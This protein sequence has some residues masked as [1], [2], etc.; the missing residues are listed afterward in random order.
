M[1]AATSGGMLSPAKKAQRSTRFEVAST[2]TTPP[3]LRLP[4]IV[5][6]ESSVY[7]AFGLDHAVEASGRMKLRTS[8][9]GATRGRRLTMDNR[10]DALSART[11]GFWSRRRA[12]SGLGAFALG[13]L[14]ILGDDRTADAR[15]CEKKCKRH[16]GHSQTNRQ[17][18]NH[19]QR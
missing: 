3:H 17:C 12:L 6:R 18:R 19:C 16:C 7:G 15:S 10:F 4:A 11:S 13:S 8:A 9:G 1:L 14:G 5:G 2:L